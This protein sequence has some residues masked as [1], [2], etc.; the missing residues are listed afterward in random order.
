M[1]AFLCFQRALGVG[2]SC[3]GTELLLA[4]F[5]ETKPGVLEWSLQPLMMRPWQTGPELGSL[6]F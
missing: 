2:V 1:L 3:T 5:R 6:G 4:S